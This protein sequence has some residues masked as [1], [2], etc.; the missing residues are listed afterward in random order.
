MTTIKGRFVYISDALYKL[1]LV[2]AN[3]VRVFIKGIY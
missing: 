3:P 2:K 1:A